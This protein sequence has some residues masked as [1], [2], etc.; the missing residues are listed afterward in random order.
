MDI[1]VFLILLVLKKNS[2]RCTF[3]LKIPI[4]IADQCSDTEVW[5][6]KICCTQQSYIKA[7]CVSHLYG[8][9]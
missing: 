2:Y 5:V 1:T 9:S 6:Y 8:W 3:P 4:Y 7:V